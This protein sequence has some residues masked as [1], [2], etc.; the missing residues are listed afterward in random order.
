MNDLIKHELLPNYEFRHISYE[1]RPVKDRDGKAVD[2]L[3]Q[4]QIALDNPKQL[5]STLLSS[6]SGA[7]LN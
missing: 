2:G 5:N 1:T 4:V 7:I 3:H 6:G